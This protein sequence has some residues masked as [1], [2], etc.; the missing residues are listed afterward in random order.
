LKLID[1]AAAGAVARITLNRPEKR[2]A[3]NGQLIG[4]LMDALERAKITDG[5]RVVVLGAA[6]QDFCAGMDIKALQ[7]TAKAD[8]S[9]HLES[10][11]QLAGLFRALR[12][13][14]HP[15]ISAVRGNALG[16][17]SGIATA[18]DV[19]LA[20]ESARFGY[21]EV[22][23]G[24]VP[25]M[26]MSLLRRSVG[27]KRAF[28]L[29][30]RGEAISASEALAAGM[31]T[32]VYSDAEFDA[33][34]ESYIAS[35]AEKSASAIALTKRLLHQIDAIPFDAALAAGVEVNAIARMTEDARRGFEK[36]TKK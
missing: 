28:D 21:P 26:V 20:A 24:F 27:E 1:F 8:V 13:H 34:T 12:F 9:Q 16:G 14:P 33:K 35:L 25:A 23:I 4:E 17:G 2:N 19:V 10:A 32:H 11:E 30:V 31:I 29:L 7:E 36:F 6:G 5:V 18:C 3:I 22:K 15:V